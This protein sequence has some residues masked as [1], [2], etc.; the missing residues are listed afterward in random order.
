MQEQTPTNT[1]IWSFLTT[2][3][4]LPTG[5]QLIHYCKVQLKLIEC[6]I[7]PGSCDSCDVSKMSGELG[8]PGR[9]NLP[10]FQV[11]VKAIYLATLSIEEFYKFNS[12]GSFLCIEHSY[13]VAFMLY[14]LTMA[15]HTLLES[16]LT[17]F[18]G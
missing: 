3:T 14:T 2:I 7:K 18:A 4:L 17:L 15:A 5:G 8:L 9:A 10:S 6:G 1:Q 11:E 16:Q 13:M 12:F